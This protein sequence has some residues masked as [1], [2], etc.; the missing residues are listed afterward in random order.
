MVA[1][2]LFLFPGFYTPMPTS[3]FEAGQMLRPNGEALETL[4]RPTAGQQ[5]GCGGAAPPR[6]TLIPMKKL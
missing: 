2:H 4:R 5:G 3:R 1:C 6:P